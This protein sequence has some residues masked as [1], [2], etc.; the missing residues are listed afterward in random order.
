MK[1][2]VETNDLA[3]RIADALLEHEER[4]QSE[5]VARIARELETTPT[6][7][8]AFSQSGDIEIKGIQLHALYS[9]SFVAERWNVSPDNVRKKSEEELP[10]SDWK[11]GEIRYRGI[12]ILRYEGVDVEEHLDGSSSQL[13]DPRGS[14]SPEAPQSKGRSS[15]PNKGSEDERPYNGDLP[16]LSDEESSPD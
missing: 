8:H 12:E 2:H 3:R 9:V 11:G 4:L 13:R 1:L 14:G 6:A 15:R 5:L 16:A 7:S 10:R